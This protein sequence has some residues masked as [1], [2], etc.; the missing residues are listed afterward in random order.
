[1]KHTIHTPTEQYGYVETEIDGTH[2]VETGIE[3]HQAAVAI[4]KAGNESGEGIP[5]KEFLAILDELYK[6]K[7]LAVDD[8]GIVQQM[9]QAQQNGLRALS[10][11]IKR[12][13]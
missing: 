12:N 3:A 6:T 7:K 13:S 11:A 5:H 8:P 2:L 9:N 1:M 4:V 10:I